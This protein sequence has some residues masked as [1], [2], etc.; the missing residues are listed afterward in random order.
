MDGDGGTLF[1]PSTFQNLAENDDEH[2]DEEEQRQ[3][4]QQVRM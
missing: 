3:I 1:N 4:E 2:E